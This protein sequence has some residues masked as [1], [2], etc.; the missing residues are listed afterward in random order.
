MTAIFQTILNMSAAGGI[1][2]LAVLLARLALRRAPKWTRL[3]LWGLVGLRL[4]VPFFVESP[5]SL[6]PRAAEVDLNAVETELISKSVPPYTAAPRAALIPTV[7][8]G[9]AATRLPSVTQSPAVTQSPSAAQMPSGQNA[10]TVAEEPAHTEPPVTFNWVRF[11]SYVWAAGALVML[12]YA[13]ISWA[14]L[15]KRLATA[16]RLD[17]NVYEADAAK[18][19]FLLGIFAPRIYLP[20]GMDARSRELVLKHERAHIKGLDHILKP[21]GWAILSIHWF[22]PLAWLAFALFSK[23]VEL[24]C[25]ERVI[26]K[27]GEPDRADYSETLL[28]L[29]VNK[30]R[31]A[32]CPLAFGESNVKERVKNVLSYKKPA[33]WIIIAAVLAAAVLAVCLLTVPKKK[34]E[35]V[36]I[37]K[38]CELARE[39]GW[40]AVNGNA[41]FVEGEEVW[42]E[43]CKKINAR[44]P[45]EVTIVLARDFAIESGRYKGMEEEHDSY[46]AFFKQITFDGRNYTERASYVYPFDFEKARTYPV[47]SSY[48]DSDGIHYYFA[49]DVLTFERKDGKVVL[50]GEAYAVFTVKLEGFIWGVTD[51]P[52]EYARENGW[53]A[54]D[55]EN[56]FVCGREIWDKFFEDQQNGVPA[57]VTIVS[58]LKVILEHETDYGDVFMVHIAKVVYDGERF[59]YTE[60][61]KFPPEFNEPKE[62]KYLIP[63]S[64][65][66]GQERYTQYVLMNMSEYLV[67]SYFFEPF[68]AAEGIMPLF[69]IVND[70]AAEF[71][72]ELSR[73]EI[74]AFLKENQIGVEELYYDESFDLNGVIRTIEHVP[75]SLSEMGIELPDYAEYDLTYAVQLYGSAEKP[76]KP[77]I[78]HM[79]REGCRNKLV[80]LGVL[81]PESVTYDLRSIVIKLEKDIDAPY[82]SDVY[83][84]YNHMVFEAIR[85][86]LKEYYGLEKEDPLEQY[87]EW[88]YRPTAD[89]RIAEWPIDL[90][91]D[92]VDE[93]FHADLDLIIGDSFSFAWVTDA[94]G[95]LM[96]NMMLCGSGHTA[97]A[98]YAVVESPEHG[99]CIM[100]IDPVFWGQSYGFSLM[101]VK[102]GE[103][104]TVYR[105]VLW[106]YD[107]D[108]PIPWDEERAKDYENRLNALLETGYVLITTDRLGVMEEGLTIEIDGTSYLTGEKLAA[109]CAFG[110]SGTGIE[111]MKET[112]TGKRAFVFS[113][114]KILYRLSIVKYEEPGEDPIVPLVPDTPLSI[115]VD[116]DGAADTLTMKD[117]GSGGVG[118]SLKLSSGESVAKTV[119]AAGEYI[120]AVV[121]FDPDNTAR[122]IVLSWTASDDEFVTQA[123]SLNG[124]KNGFDVFTAPIKVDKKI[125]DEGYRFVPYRGLPCARHTEIFGPWVVFGYFTVT[126]EG[127]AFTDEFEYGATFINGYTK[128]FELKR[129]LNV[130]VRDE[131]GKMTVSHTVLP[132]EGVTP[133]FT[134]TETFVAV[135]LDDGRLAYIAITL[136]NGGG[137]VLFNGIEQ[138]EYS[139]RIWRRRDQ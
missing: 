42:N 47:L 117:Y 105:E 19:P 25:D 131:S 40:V 24:A 72:S 64:V 106:Q 7:T 4:A 104:T 63:F 98:T 23:D 130:L 5:L 34:G 68:S 69:M 114:E 124:G 51:E 83:F 31:I 41:R 110:S 74:I 139:D 112:T 136:E 118:L 45:A 33:L 52:Y 54:L 101:T 12:A 132:G 137:T 43:F 97:Y 90:D 35:F 16:V 38:G 81:I 122:E 59:T 22:D 1:L 71:L 96:G 29:S 82:P 123:L 80:E 37:E 36:S 125:F 15:K 120:A 8:E 127:I 49:N 85:T 78:S 109:V 95:K 26:R 3:V 84:D 58:T 14:A 107:P 62:F 11:A 27:L 121:D 126:G 65:I 134:D 135:R 30:R 32:A 48:D 92:G 88:G 113:N 28:R 18:T 138:H 53:V 70:T 111:R 46:E 86:A 2:I 20:F 21:L 75:Y 79:G 61:S 39:N 73:E 99:T 76:D 10:G 6:M 57:E 17:G 119:P 55:F 60:S 56:D 13:A 102:D 116:G 115:D 50:S 89:S 91:G 77:V 93:V 108:D 67:A 94:R 44:E 9:P 66:K 87:A 129:E 103:F 100:R 128:R 133:I